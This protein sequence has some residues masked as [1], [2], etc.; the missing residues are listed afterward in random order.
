MSDDMVD[1]QT[2][3]LNQSM[4]TNAKVRREIEN[5]ERLARIERKLDDIL[6]RMGNVEQKKVSK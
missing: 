2:E 5:A 3:A 6:A 1:A 4:T